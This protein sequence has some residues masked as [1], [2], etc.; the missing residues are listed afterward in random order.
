VPE[1]IKAF[2]AAGAHFY[3][4][5]I[6]VSPVGSLAVRITRQFQVARKLG[7]THQNVLIFVKGDA[8]KAT[9]ACGQVWV[10]PFEAIQ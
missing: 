3:N 8:K 5:A 10:Q 7:R 4:E 6:L 1:T 9:E 2:Q